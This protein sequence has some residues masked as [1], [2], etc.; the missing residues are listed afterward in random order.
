MKKF[1]ILSLTA[2]V[3]SLSVT[4]VYAQKKHKSV[5]KPPKTVSMHRYVRRKAMGH[6]PFVLRQR[7]PEAKKS[8]PRYLR[9]ERR[10]KRWHKR[11]TVKVRSHTSYKG[12]R[13][14][15]QHVSNNDAGVV[16]SVPEA[17]RFFTER[18]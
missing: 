8:H 18:P 1:I 17:L 13:L 12:R 6:S 11:N 14:A 4:P 10:L 3:L 16:R 15:K 9:S 2:L 7:S 5:L